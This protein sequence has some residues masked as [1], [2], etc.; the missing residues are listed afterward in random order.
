MTAVGS[1]LV[2]DLAYR[3]NAPITR[4]T[5]SLA[6]P[7]QAGVLFE[8]TDA[9]SEVTWSGTADDLEPGTYT[10][11]VSAEVQRNGN[12]TSGSTVRSIEVGGV[13]ALPQ[14]IAAVAG[15]A[16]D[17]GGGGTSLPRRR[18]RRTS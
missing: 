8:T 11:T 18:R 1:A 6:G 5:V 15:D 14:P 7:S 2:I 9:P 4:F 10:V 3:A 16:C 12:R 13:P 17:R